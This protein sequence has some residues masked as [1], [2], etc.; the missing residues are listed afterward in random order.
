MT[1][2]FTFIEVKPPTLPLTIT[3]PYRLEG[4]HGGYTELV[5][6][7]NEIHLVSVSG[8]MKGDRPDFGKPKK[9][10]DRVVSRHEATNM[11]KDA[12]EYKADMS[13]YTRLYCAVPSSWVKEESN[14]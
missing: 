10:N 8:D 4:D 12:L 3:L 9:T 14:D 2:K 6:E 13:G 7:D 11:I 1:L 5:A